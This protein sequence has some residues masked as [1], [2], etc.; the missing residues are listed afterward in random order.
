MIT[1]AKN[2]F[3]FFGLN[4]DCSRE[5]LDK[6][7]RA[8]ALETHPDHGGE[9]ER[10]KE[11]QQHYE[12]ACKKLD[13]IISN[14]IINLMEAF[15]ALTKTDEPDC[16][17][18]TDPEVW[19]RYPYICNHCGYIAG[20]GNEHIFVYGSLSSWHYYASPECW[21][22]EQA[23]LQ[24]KYEQERRQ[25]SR[26][27]FHLE[28]RRCLTCRRVIYAY[29]GDRIRKCPYCVKDTIRRN[30]KRHVNPRDCVNCGKSFQPKR[31]DAKYCSAACRQQSYRS[32]VTG[33]YQ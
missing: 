2:S 28:R 23:R 33:N 12:T 25:E 24:W 15:D 17:D 26:Q 9:A 27:W 6:V 29:R 10:F 18:L 30:R 8:K 19:K 32:R 22:K 4:D 13:G 16:R 14:P 21:E 5:E 11:V 1:A 7:F 3:D 31:S 20:Y